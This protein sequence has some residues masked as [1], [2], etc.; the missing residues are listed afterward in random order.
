MKH[1]QNTTITRGTARLGLLL[2]VF[3]LTAFGSSEEVLPQ[4]ILLENTI[5]QRVS[6]AVYRV[7]KNEN[8]IVN[9]NVEM[10]IV[11]AQEYTTVY[12][13]PGKSGESYTR[14]TTTGASRPPQMITDPTPAEANSATGTRKVMKQ[15][16]IQTSMPSDIPGFPGIQ[17]PGFELYEETI[18]SETEEAV[19][20]AEAGDPIIAG[21][22]TAEGIVRQ[23]FQEV[24]ADTDVREEAL[25]GE[26]FD[27]ETAASAEIT[28]EETTPPRMTR[29][30][31]ASTSSPTYRVDKMQLTIIMEDPVSPQVVENIRTVAMVA[32]HFNRERGDDLQVMT[33]AFSGSDKEKGA[34]AEELLLKS[35][36]EKMTA[37]EARTRQEEEARKL[38]DQEDKQLK[39]QKELQDKQAREAE[40][41]RLR[42]LEEKRL[43][44]R[45]AEERRIQERETELVRIREAEEQRLAEERRR[46]FEDQQQQAQERLRQ[47]SLRLALLTEQL[48][49]LKTQL[50]AVDLEEEQRL[51]IELEQKRRQAEKTALQDKQNE[52]KDRLKEIEDM[53]LKANT[54][55]PATTLDSTLVYLILGGA[56]ILAFLIAM[57]VLMS[58]RRRRLPPTSGREA[59]SAG[60]MDDS[61]GALE[62][63]EEGG[64]DEEAETVTSDDEILAMAESATAN[65]KLKD[66]VDT[67]KKSV[68]SMAVSKPQSASNIIQTWLQDTGASAAAGEGEAVETGELVA[69]EKGDE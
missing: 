4:K 30:T 5:H 60:P 20:Y 12:E 28:Y 35:I 41:T 34:D 17:R 36:S 69:N 10:G 14:S 37:I 33:A 52:L 11:P 24:P 29:H 31:V 68:V 66:E 45:E 1:P 39:A 50:S 7:L 9:V 23:P 59:L 67:I 64:D 56:I 25:E 63:F 65:R 61:G 62:E 40:M 6:D 21:A 42:E 15:R 47:D 3:S 13:T 18:P 49:D 46:L 58:G 8:F 54:V 27:R 16:Q 53:K 57:A 55:Q 38:K 51:K 32:S 44:Q 19:V 2:A 26:T 43:E 48:N 22:D